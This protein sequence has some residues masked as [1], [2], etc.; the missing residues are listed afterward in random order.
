MG[1]PLRYAVPMLSRINNR[2]FRL[3]VVLAAFSFTAA[4]ASKETA[5]DRYVHLPDASY[6]WDLVGTI[7]GDGFKAYVLDLTSQT[8]KPPVEPDRT[9]WK[10]WLTVYVPTMVSHTTGFLYITGGNNRS[11]APDKADPWMAEMATATN[12]VVAE[13]RMVPNQPLNF[14]DAKSKDLTEDAFIAYTWDKFLRTGND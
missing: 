12:S 3:L 5:L 9:V 13:L 6:K 8:W 11:A 1:R 10:H 7:P 4:A 14:P 2:G